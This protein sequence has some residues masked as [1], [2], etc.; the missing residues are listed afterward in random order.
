M[1]KY[2]SYLSVTLTRFPTPFNE[3]FSTIGPR[4]AR[5]NSCQK[6]ACK[7]INIKECQPVNI[8]STT[9]NFKCILKTFS[10][11]CD[12]NIS[13]MATNAVGSAQSL[14]YLPYISISSGIV[15]LADSFVCIV[16][17]TFETSIWNEN[18]TA[19]GAHKV[20]G[21]SRN[22][23]LAGHFPVLINPLSNLAIL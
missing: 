4:L 7:L 23:P 8:I 3:H 2:V 17:K 10:D 15:S 1:S 11:A 14:I 5:D 21:P 22:R 16:L 13:V 18:R 6:T 19:I 20:Q 12:Y 9:M